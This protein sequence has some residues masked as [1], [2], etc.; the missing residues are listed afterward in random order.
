[1]HFCD[2]SQLKR[3]SWR[4]TIH[5]EK[6][7]KTWLELTALLNNWSKTYMR[8][9]ERHPYLILYIYIYIYTHII[10]T[11]IMGYRPAA[12]LQIAKK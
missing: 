12:D 6:T 11:H 2:N 9:R 5:S 8:R 10:Y 1:M 7:G 4:G 3:E